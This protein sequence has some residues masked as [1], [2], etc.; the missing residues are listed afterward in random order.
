MWAHNI[1][2]AW[3]FRYEKMTEQLQSWGSDQWFW[4]QEWVKTLRLIHTSMSA[5]SCP[6]LSAAVPSLTG[7]WAKGAVSVVSLTWAQVCFSLFKAP[8]L[9]ARTHG[10]SHYYVFFFFCLFHTSTHQ[11]L[12]K[13][14]D[15]PEKFVHGPP[16]FDLWPD[17][18]SDR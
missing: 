6:C 7:S 18:R 9:P 4:S 11:C 14:L 10:H 5:T 17:Q 13:S 3:L 2:V 1:K 15:R 8:F 12:Q 16:I